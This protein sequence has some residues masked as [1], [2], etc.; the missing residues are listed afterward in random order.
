[1]LKDIGVGPSMYLLVIRGLRNLF[2]M[3]T[4]INLP[5][6]YIYAS[7][8]GTSRISWSS[9]KIFGMFSNGNLG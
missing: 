9:E 8:D 2:F 7:G 5:I 4:L 1:M 3:L 6:M